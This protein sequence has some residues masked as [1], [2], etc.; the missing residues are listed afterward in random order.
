[1]ELVVNDKNTHY[2]FMKFVNGFLILGCVIF[3]IGVTLYDYESSRQDVDYPF[4]VFTTVL[5]AI[6]L[7]M[8]GI[9]SV[10]KFFQKPRE[11]IRL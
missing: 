1:M 9:F 6:G 11:R 3:L 8:I 10:I 4:F 2:N 7:I 5:M